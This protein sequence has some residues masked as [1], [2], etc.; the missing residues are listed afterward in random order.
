MVNP[1]WQLMLKRSFSAWTV[2]VQMCYRVH[3]CV[4]MFTVLFLTQRP[5]SYLCLCIFMVMSCRLIHESVCR[6]AASQAITLSHVL[7]CETELCGGINER[8]VH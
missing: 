1:N 4:S 2:K 5:L 7:P 3:V 6:T 8:C